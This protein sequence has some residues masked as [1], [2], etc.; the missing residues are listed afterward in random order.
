MPPEKVET[1]IIGAGLAGLT[2][3]TVLQSAKHDCHVI[4]AADA[5]GGRVRTDVVNGF[6][7][8]RGFQ[9]LLTAYPTA[10]K[11]LD[12]SS[13]DLRS[14]EPG[15]WIRWQNNWK[16]LGDPWRRPSTTVA[17]M[18]NPVG[19]LIDK[20]RIGLL[21]RR[22]CRGTLADVY[23]R[24]NEPTI[25]YLKSCGFSATMIDGFFRPFLG[26]VFLDPSLQTSR[27]MFEFVFRM[28]AKGDI[29]IPASGMQAIPEQLAAKIGTDNI[30]LGSTAEKID[31]GSVKLTSGRSILAKQII[32][33]IA[34]SSATALVGQ[35]IHDQPAL[36][37]KQTFNL[38]FSVPAHVGQVAKFASSKTLL[39]SGDESDGLIQTATVVSGLSASLAGNDPTRHLVSVS[40]R[41]NADQ[42]V[43]EMDVDQSTDGAAQQ[44]SRWLDC[45]AGDLKFLRAYPI[46]FGLPDLNY[47]PVQQSVGPLVMPSHVEATSN[48]QTKVYVAGDHLSTPSIEGAM[49]SG[50]RAAEAILA[51]A[52]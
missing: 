41:V 1:L 9:V 38:Y 14:F 33:A 21:R 20:A 26:G 10:Q 44:L 50:Q 47:D 49:S 23:Q 18:T 6:R 3:A 45:S 32:L 13:L 37:W 51:S 31:G 22:V 39:L 11:Y 28:F 42:D 35:P 12:Y 8:D 27:R 5:V 24:P 36:R 48:N 2:A 30:S 15:A 43:L 17:T 29:A 46:R 40:L 34:P 4:E 16:Q 25:E 19:S 7:L 52:K